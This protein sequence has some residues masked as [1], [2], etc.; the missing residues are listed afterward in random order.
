MI[1]AFIWGLLPEN[2]LV[3]ERWA[4]KFQVSARSP[5][6]LISQVGEDCAGAVQFVRPDRLYAVFNCGPG[7]IDWL[8]ESDIAVRLKTLREDHSAWRRPGDTGQFS[9]AGA[10]PKTALS[11]QDGKW[12][13]PSGRTSH[14]PYSEAPDRCLRRPRRKRTFLSCTCARPRNAGRIIHGHAFRR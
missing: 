3:L 1:E 12:G 14:N 4:K 11:L 6:A 5:F 7:D 13:V 10:Q 8:D 2:E 9:L